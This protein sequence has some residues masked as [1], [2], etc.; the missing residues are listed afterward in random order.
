MKK[1]L[2]SSGIENIIPLGK[3][4]ERLGYQ[5]K[6]FDYNLAVS[7]V[8]EFFF[9]PANNILRALHISRDKPLGRTS[10][11]KSD[12]YRIDRLRCLIR[13]F[14]PDMFLHER[15]PALPAEL[16]RDSK[17][18]YGV[19]LTV[20]WWTKGLQWVDMAIR[21]AELYDYYFFIH[22]SFVDECRKAGR[23]NCFYLPY[24][25]DKDVF[26]KVDLS[27]CDRDRFGCD[28]AF[29]GGWFPNRQEIMENII[30][31]SDIRLKIWGP[32][33]RK[34]NI[35]RPKIFKSVS[36]KGLYGSDLVKQYAAAKINL[37]ISKWIGKSDSG[38]NLR[39]FEIPRC[40]GF[41]LTDY[42]EELGE[43]YDVGKE[44]ETYRDIEELRD[45]I[46]FYLKND[47]A[48]RDIAAKGYEKAMKLPGWEERIREMMDIVPDSGG[49]SR[50]A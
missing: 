23:D 22:R 19:K 46:G 18:E 34:K 39:I 21:D 44:I 12:R 5:V 33:W 3:T 32:K 36:G 29:V 17:T 27:Q 6:V 37:N 2:V 45:K 11:F 24:A 16:L 7:P 13:E 28:V 38:L 50:N 9:K 41:L 15:G 25:V 49:L 20:A 48:R 35:L 31:G 4:F 14:S 30:S 26:A 40:G 1:L 47:P 8:D 42:I 10:R 43:F